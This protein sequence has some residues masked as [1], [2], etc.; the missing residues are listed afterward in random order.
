MSREAIQAIIELVAR[1]PEHSLPNY[2]RYCAQE[3][4]AC[5]EG[6]SEVTHKQ[7][8][9]C[10]AK[11]PH[12]HEGIAMLHVEWLRLWMR[13]HPDSYVQVLKE[14]LSGVLVH[15]CGSLA[16]NMCHPLDWLLATAL[17][18]PLKSQFWQELSDNPCFVNILSRY[19]PKAYDPNDGFFATLGEFG[20]DLLKLIPILD[21][22]EETYWKLLGPLRLYLENETILSGRRPVGWLKKLAEWPQEQLNQE[23]YNSLLLAYP[24]AE[25]CRYLPQLPKE[26]YHIY[27][28]KRLLRCRLRW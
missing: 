27:V 24:L 15:K 6:Q 9:D 17:P 13:L 12:Y 10:F 26:F 28:V 23:A 3:L 2:V 11:N 21:S 7:L 5:F 8:I 19:L 1:V 18:E 20:E 16:S 22:K 25:W 4:M 14:H